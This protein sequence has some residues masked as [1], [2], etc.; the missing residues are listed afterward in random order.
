M[1]C[2]DDF[3]PGGA[4]NAGAGPHVSNQKR[5]S[6]KQGEAISQ[7]TNFI[8]G[9][10]SGGDHHFNGAKGGTTQKNISS[11]NSEDTVAN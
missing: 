8:N 4:Y 5:K 9:A 11:N 1:F 7:H 3:K 10:T 6:S 2:T